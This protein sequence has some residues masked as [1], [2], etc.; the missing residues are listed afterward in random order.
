M[1][2][3]VEILNLSGDTFLRSQSSLSHSRCLLSTI[4]TGSLLK[5]N[6]LISTVLLLQYHTPISAKIVMRVNKEPDNL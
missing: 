6:E 2:A 5:R 4:R 3:G 1:G